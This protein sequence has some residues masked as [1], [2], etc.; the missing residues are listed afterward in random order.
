MDTKSHIKAAHPA[1]GTFHKRLFSNLGLNGMTKLLVYRAIVFSTLLCAC[2]TLALYH[3]DIRWQEL[4]STTK[5]RQILGTK[6]KTASP[7]MKSCAK[8]RQSV[9]E[10]VL[11]DTNF[12]SWTSRIRET[13][14]LC[15]KTLRFKDVRKAALKRINI[16]YQLGGNPC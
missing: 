5:P 2:E 14:S 3:R 15:P 16:R 6:E 8:L 11:R 13:T 12:I 1:F 9:Y 7:A 4:F 10:S